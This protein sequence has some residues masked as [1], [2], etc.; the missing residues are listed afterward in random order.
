VVESP[1]ITRDVLEN[2]IPYAL[3]KNHWKTI[4]TPKTTKK[5]EVSSVDVF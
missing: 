1:L 5:Q 3:L 4:Y 2:N